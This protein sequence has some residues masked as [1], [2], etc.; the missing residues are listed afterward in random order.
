[1]QTK[2]LR[3]EIVLEVQFIQWHRSCKNSLIV[4][5]IPSYKQRGRLVVRKG[6]GTIT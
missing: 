6:E 3:R 4:K 5:N 1:M 2:Q